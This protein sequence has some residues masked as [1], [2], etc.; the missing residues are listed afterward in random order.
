M[1]Q[2][3]PPTHDRESFSYMTFKDILDNPVE[4]EWII[5]D[6]IPKGDSTLIHA[7]GGVGKSMFGVNTVLSLAAHGTDPK[8]PLDTI[9][10]RF[11]VPKSRATLF[12]QAENSPVAMY[13]R[14]HAMTTGNPTLKKGLSKVFIL[15]QYKNPTITGECFSDPKFCTF[16]V[17]F[18]EDIE[19]REK[20]KIDLIIIDPLI[21]YLD[22]NENDSVQTRATLDGISRIAIQAEVTP[23][24]IHHANK[25]GN[26]YRGSTAINDWARNRI[27]LKAEEGTKPDTDQ[28]T[29]SLIPKL[30]KTKL[31]R[32][33]HE[34]YNNFESFNSFLL[35]MGSDLNFRPVEEQLSEK[36][37][38]TCKKVVQALEKLEG[39]AGS[40]N[41]LA[42]AYIDLFKGSAKTA[43]RHIENA[44]KAGYISK[45]ATVKDGK[46]TYVYS[47]P[48][49]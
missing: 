21:S 40:Q 16:V 28:K 17:K 11:P 4:Q 22:G 12:I 32:V 24:V 26:N 6:L 5:E 20:V 2:N 9:F 25:L 35:E 23:I 15:S 47:L 39:H 10:G 19:K 36:D 49:E 43:K 38:E 30:K 13:Q 45:E 7:P 34:K 37:I 8:N 44:E 46:E 41:F 42:K 14:I 31:V 1:T 29:G 18:I 3:K 27:S 33:T 48:T